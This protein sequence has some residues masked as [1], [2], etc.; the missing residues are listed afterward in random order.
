MV[1]HF[2]SMGYIHF[3]GHTVNCRLDWDCA[4]VAKLLTQKKW[5]LEETYL[6]SWVCAHLVLTSFCHIWLQRSRKET[7]SGWSSQKSR[8]MDG[9]QGKPKSLE[10]SLF[11][12]YCGGEKSNI[13]FDY[14]YKGFSGQYDKEWLQ[15]WAL[16]GN[17]EKENHTIIQV[18]WMDLPGSF[19]LW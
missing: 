5:E 14:E 19:W 1:H 8:P 16:A 3:M 12:F 10:V 4:E 7:M 17:S 15:E 13:L 18:G 6:E 11:F 2:L 9:T